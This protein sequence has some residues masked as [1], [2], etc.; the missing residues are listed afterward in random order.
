MYLHWEFHRDEVYACSTQNARPIMLKGPPPGS[1]TPQHKTPT[2][3]PPV[4][5]EKGGSGVPQQ[6][7]NDTREGAVLRPVEPR[8]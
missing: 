5:P 2:P 7:T 4:D 8:G 3:P 6:N 1:T